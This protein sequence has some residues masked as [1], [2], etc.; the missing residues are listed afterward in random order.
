[1]SAY[2]M[3]SFGTGLAWLRTFVLKT[4]EPTTNYQALLDV[5]IDRLVEKGDGAI[6]DESEYELNENGD[7]FTL[8]SDP[9]WTINDDEFVMGGN[10]C[11]ALQHYGMFDITK[12]EEIPEYAEEVIEVE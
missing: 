2:Y 3:I 6:I 12:I 10:C 4:D 11:N 7:Q 5:L 9:S 8:K 1:M